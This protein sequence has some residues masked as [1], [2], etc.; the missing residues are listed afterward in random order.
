MK[1]DDKNLNQKW[2]DY[3]NTRITGNRKKASELLNGFITTLLQND[4]KV[5]E[6]FVHQ[7]CSIVLKN[8]TF[9]STNSIEIASAEVR[10][11]HPLFQ[12]VLVP[13]FIKKYK[14]NDPLYIKWIAQMEQFF[15]SDQRI[16]YYFLEE[17][18]DKLRD[19]VQFSKETNQYEEIKC[20]YFE[21]DYFLKKSF[22]LKADQEV[23]D[24]ILK[25][26]LKDI[27][28][29]THELPYLLTDLDD[30]IEIINEFKYFSEQSESKEKWKAQI[31]EWENIADN[32]KT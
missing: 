27:D 1:L 11:Q 5:I 16:T 29:L 12:K 32:L 25:R 28:Y 6:N 17:I 9:V 13:I 10:I 8:N 15:Y 14:E 18:D 30:F 3:N 4:E 24:L 22:E 19:A 7:I 20:R 26:M 21:T 2:S 31:E 23:L